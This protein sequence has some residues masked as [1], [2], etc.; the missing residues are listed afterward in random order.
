M[1]WIYPAELGAAQ[2]L[3]SIVEIISKEI[4]GM[5]PLD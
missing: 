2:T 3:G 5:M 1:P 4:H